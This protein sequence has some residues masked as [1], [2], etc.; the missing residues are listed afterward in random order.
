MNAAKGKMSPKDK[1]LLVLPYLETR[2]VFGQEKYGGILCDTGSHQIEQFLV[3]TGAV[4][5]LVVS[6]RA[7][8]VAY[9]ET[10]ELE[11]FGEA[12][13]VGDNSASGYL[14]GGRR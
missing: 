3:Y 6:A 8:N 14:R 10:P 12:S 11:D 2:L 13:L 7:E 5:A 4:D 1:S 9:P